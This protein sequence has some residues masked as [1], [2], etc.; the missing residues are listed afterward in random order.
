L[1]KKRIRI[2]RRRRRRRML[3][4][5]SMRGES[6]GSGQNTKDRSL[7]NHIKAIGQHYKSIN[8][9]LSSKAPLL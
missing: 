6:E 3:K 2:R 5:K 4:E 9:P 8:R 1:K 7:K